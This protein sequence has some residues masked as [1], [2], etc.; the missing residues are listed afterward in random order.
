MGWAGCRPDAYGR[1]AP[2]SRTNASFMATPLP[3]VAVN[4]G[5]TLPHRMTFQMPGS[6]PPER[7]QAPQWMST[8][9]R[10]T[11]AAQRL[12]RERLLHVKTTELRSPV[13]R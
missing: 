2:G 4:V 5:E 9:R 12:A 6:L 3:E 13:Y 8:E 10:R 11:E 7:S 1:P